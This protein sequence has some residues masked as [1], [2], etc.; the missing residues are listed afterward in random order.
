[1]AT[2]EHST[3]GAGELHE[4][5]GITTASNGMVYVADGSNSGDWVPADS[6]IAG[7]VAFDASTPA[8]QHSTTTSDTVL[9]PTFS[10]ASSKNFSGTDTPNARLV[11]DGTAAVYGSMNFVSSVRQSSGSDKELEMVIYKNGTEM[12]GTRN[13][14]T[15]ASGEWHTFA[16]TGVVALTTD[17]YIEVFVKADAAHTTDFASAQLNITAFP[18]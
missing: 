13:I 2:I 3:L 9:D 17:D 18:G 4:P 10:V 11:Y 14:V 16:M 6:H 5:K 12:S 7:Y 8:Y 15:I 1:M